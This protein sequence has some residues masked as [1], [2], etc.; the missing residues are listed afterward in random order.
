MVDS[1]TP[2]KVLVPVDLSRSGWEEMEPFELLSSTRSLLLG[3]YPIKDQVSLDQAREQLEGKV[4]ERLRVLAR[5]FSEV[6]VDPETEV[7]FFKSYS[8]T[9]DRAVH[10]HDCSAVISW[11]RT[12]RFE[13]I[14]AFVKCQQAI[15]HVIEIVGW[16]LID[17]TQEIELVH[18]LD[19]DTGPDEREKRRSALRSAVGHLKS[20]GIP[21]ERVRTRVEEVDDLKEAMRRTV[22]DYDA[23]VMGETER[24]G[25]ARVFGTLHEAIQE[26]TD[27]AVVVV[28]NPEEES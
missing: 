26:E 17:R 20:R 24:K 28:R 6:G 19:A 5:R 16:L 15:D 10:E 14:G 4:R 13:R 7:A 18:F 2:P 22:H 11:S 23:L 9:I 25:A 8:D 1:I 21:E 27:G 3:L 12:F